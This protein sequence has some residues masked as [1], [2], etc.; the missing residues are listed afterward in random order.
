MEAIPANPV[1]WL[2]KIIAISGK[3]LVQKCG[4]DGYLFIRFIR[5]MLIIFVPLMAIVVTVLLP[6]NYNGGE[7]DRVFIVQ[8]HPKSFNVTGLDTLA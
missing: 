3:E 7:G 2:R 5:A 6:V 8:G 1:L 4:L